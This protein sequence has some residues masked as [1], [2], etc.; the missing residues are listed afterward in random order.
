MNELDHELVNQTSWQ[1][2]AR[3]HCLDEGGDVVSELLKLHC[4]LNSINVIGVKE[5][6]VTEVDDLEDN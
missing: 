4:I 5:V 1:H 3:G 6:Q 2:N